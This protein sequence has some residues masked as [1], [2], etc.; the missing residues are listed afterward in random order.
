VSK[1]N[2]D[3]RRAIVE[4]ALENKGRTVGMQSYNSDGGRE[5]RASGL[6]C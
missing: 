2:L 3:E 4:M 1:V 5:K 6:L